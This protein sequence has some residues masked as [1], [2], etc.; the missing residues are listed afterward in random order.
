MTTSKYIFSTLSLIF[1]SFFNLS[2]QD[3]ISFMNPS[4]EDPPMLTKDKPRCC[5]GP[6]GWYACGAGDLNTPDAQPGNFN[7]NLP[8]ADGGYYVGM[9]T[10]DNDTW[11]AISQR[12][13]SPLVK[14]DCYTFSLKISHSDNLISE[15]R[16]TGKNVKYNKPVKVRIWAGN[17]YCQKLQLLDESPVIDHTYWKQYNFRFEPIRDFSYV[18][19][20]VFYKT[21]TPIPY[22]GNILLDDASTILL[23]PCDDEPEP[24]IVD[25][26]QPEPKDPLNVSPSS[27]PI[28]EPKPKPEP[29]PAETIVSSTD[30]KDDKDTDYKVSNDILKLDRKKLVKG[31]VIKIENLY[32]KADSTNITNDSYPVLDEIYGFLRSNPDISIE[33]GGHTNNRCESSFCDDLSEQRAKAVADYLIGKGIRSRRLL[34]KGYGKRNPIASNTYR[35][36]RKKNQRV[37]IKI[38]DLDG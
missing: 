16:R 6:R 1:C 36:G 37:E 27:K 23:V 32:F 10:R 31:Q 28:V 22:N 12:L 25:I 15:S 13:R 20:E 19:I 35:A 7:V 17:G 14:G 18:T 34:F 26:D 30:T 8:A 29:K 38:L 21:P 33:I 24:P 4:F 2:A 5:I 9:V 11:E 3:E